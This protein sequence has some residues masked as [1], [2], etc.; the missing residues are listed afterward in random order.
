MKVVLLLAA[1]LVLAGCGTPLTATTGT[2]ASAPP[3]PGNFDDTDVMFLQMLIP[4]HEQG[5]ELA[6]LARTRARS[7]EVREFAAAVVATQT[8]EVEDMRSWLRAWNQPVEADPDAH[9]HAGHGGMRLTDPDVVASLADTPA[10]AFDRTFLNLFTGHQHGAVE[11]A[12]LETRG[13]KD[14]LATG[15]ASRIVESRTAQVRQLARLLAR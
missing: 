8:D 10:V 11:L 7:A 3:L 15:L 14:P 13:G 5:I 4:H 12:R 6:R 9:A 2:A 1:V